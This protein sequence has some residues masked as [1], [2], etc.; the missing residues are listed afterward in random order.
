MERLILTELTDEGL[1]E[2]SERAFDALSEATTAVNCLCFDVVG[3]LDADDRRLPAREYGRLAFF[4]ANA[5]SYI[6]E[7]QAALNGARRVLSL[8]TLDDVG[9]VLMPERG[10]ES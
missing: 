1:A 2:G 9:V 8:T 3:L 10:N 4:L 6:E 7:M 5:D